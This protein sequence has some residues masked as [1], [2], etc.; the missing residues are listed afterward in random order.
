MHGTGIRCRIEKLPA[1]IISAIE[2]SDSRKAFERL[3]YQGGSGIYIV[4]MYTTDRTHRA[5]PVV[6]TARL[7]LDNGQPVALKLTVDSLRYSPGRDVE[8]PRVIDELK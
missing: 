1:A 6:T 7:V 4:Q 2:K 3:A 8:N 5:V